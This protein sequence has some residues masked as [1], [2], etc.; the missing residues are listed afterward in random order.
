MVGNHNACAR[1]VGRGL[2]VAN[3]P[4]STTGGTLA[5][6]PETFT[7][8]RKPEGVGFL[9]RAVQPPSFVY[10]ENED[11]I[12]VACAS[13]QSNETVTINYRLL[14]FD[15]EIIEGQ[16]A[17]RPASDRSVTSYSE[18]LAEGF[19]L[20][21]SARAAVATTRG[22]TFLRVFLTS[23]AFGGVLPSYMLFADYVTTQMAPAHPNG[24]VLSPVEGPGLVR[25]V[26]ITQPIAGAD[27]LLTVPSNARWKPRSFHGFFTTSAAVAN[28]YVAVSFARTG[29]SLFTGGADKVQ[30]ASVGCDYGGAG[31]TPNVSP[32]AAVG[33]F[34]IPPE[35]IMLPGDTF[36]SFT[37]NIQAADQWTFLALGVDEWL[38]NV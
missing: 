31:L 22:Q 38:D 26:G 15:G 20:S 5:A 24:R 23:P 14:R 1:M 2:T 3:D 10:V 12:A 7:F 4:H 21:V 9:R 33:S 37:A 19:L 36:S 30:A 8:T 27:F 16:F 6:T 28:R 35:L 11:D 13:S 17:I 25:A 29:I 18:S 32:I 34:P